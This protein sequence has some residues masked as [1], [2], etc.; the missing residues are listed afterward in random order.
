MFDYD[1]DTYQHTRTSSCSQRHNH[2]LD[3]TD[4]EATLDADEW[5]SIGKFLDS[6]PPE[7]I[8]AH[9]ASLYEAFT[10]QHS[11]RSFVDALIGAGYYRR[12]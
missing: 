6:L 3:S 7:A 9:T 12:T 11:I 5:G 8:V 2:E 1:Q 10:L 4:A